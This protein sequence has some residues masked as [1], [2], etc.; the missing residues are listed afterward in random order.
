[1]DRLYINIKWAIDRFRNN[2]P[3]KKLEITTNLGG[4]VS[5]SNNSSSLIPSQTQLSKKNRKEAKKSFSLIFDILSKKLEKANPDTVRQLNSKL[6]TSTYSEF[7]NQI[8]QEKVEFESNIEIYR[9][10]SVSSSKSN[11]VISSSSSI[12]LI[13]IQKQK[14]TSKKS[15]PLSRK[16]TNGAEESGQMEIDHVKPKINREDKDN[17]ERDKINRDLLFDYNP[18][19]NY[20]NYNNKTDQKNIDQILIEEDDFVKKAYEKYNI[21]NFCQVKLVDCFSTDLFKGL[22]VPIK[23]S[24]DLKQALKLGDED[25]QYDDIEVV[26][27]KKQRKSRKNIW[28]DKK[29]PKPN[30][31]KKE[32]KKK[33]SDLFQ[34]DKKITENNTNSD[35]ISEN[36]ALKRK[37]SESGESNELPKLDLDLKQSIDSEKKDQISDYNSPD[38]KTCL[39]DSLAKK[40]NFSGSVQSSMT[41]SRIKAVIDNNLSVNLFSDESTRPSKR[42]R[43]KRNFKFNTFLK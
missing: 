3:D 15:R 9:R 43:S 41:I 27:K 30:K 5:D 23:L 31:K 40:L 19:T 42:T 37:R 1:M 34:K 20:F 35:T 6:Y 12:N 32:V 17:V 39:N 2:K 29:R 24:E 26:T 16:S 8:K 4:Q 38:Q 14:R 21:K 22:K 10:S 18:I 25:D 7:L 11:E 33:Q 13:E 36:G 28:R